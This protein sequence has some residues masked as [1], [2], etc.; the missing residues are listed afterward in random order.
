[1]MAV[2]APMS[3]VMNGNQ[4]GDPKL[5]VVRMVDLIKGKGMATGR[6]IPWPN[7]DGMRCSQCCQEEVPGDFEG[8]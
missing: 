5:G 6:P 3:A 8:D 1:M 2:I 4:R 7:A